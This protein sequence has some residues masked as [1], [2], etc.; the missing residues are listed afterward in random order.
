MKNLKNYL[1]KL[2][3][4]TD[5]SIKE[6]IVIITSFV[7]SS[8]LDLIGIGLLSIYVTLLINPD[9]IVNSYI[10]TKYHFLS[11]ITSFNQLANIVGIILVI[12][13]VLKLLISV[14]IYNIVFKFTHS[15]Q[16]LLRQKLLNSYKKLSY[17][18]Y[19]YRDS[20]DSIASIGVYVKNYGAVING[21]LLFIGDMIIAF[22]IVLLLLS[23][24][25]PFF[26]SIVFLLTLVVYLYKILLLNNFA[27]LGENL[28]KGYKSIY[29]GVQ[30]Y[31]DGFKE[32][33]VLNR[34]SYFEDKIIS[35]TDKVA[36]SDIKQSIIAAIPK[37][38]IELTIVI[39]MV[40]IVSYTIIT[41]GIISDIIPLLTLFAAASIRLAPMFNQISRFFSS[42]SYGQNSILKLYDENPD[43]IL[44]KSRRNEVISFVKGGL[45][46]LS[47]S[48][49]TFDWGIKVPNDQ[50]HIMYVWLDALS[51]YPNSLG[52][53]SNNKSKLS[54]YWSNTVHI[55]GKDILRHHAVYW[56]AFLLSAKLELPKRIFAHGWWT[57]E[58]N[59]ISKSLGNTIDPIE[60]I[61]QFGLDQIRYFLLREI[62][63]GSDGDFSTEALKSRINA[64]LSNDLGNLCQRSLTMIVKHCGAIIPGDKNITELD[65]K[66]LSRIS[67]ELS[68][69]SLHVD[70]QEINIYIKKIWDVVAS[71]NK[72]FNDN[73][74]W[75]LKSTDKKRFESVLF[76]TAETIKQIAVMI[77]PIMPDT[78]KRILDFYNIDVNNITLEILSFNL[79]NIKINEIN[80]LFPRVE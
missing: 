50:K 60:I 69:L 42:F 44:P 9:L 5:A 26:L 15:R 37:L 66:L 76:V 14:L 8:L 67:N 63:F 43:F 31:F 65:K 3:K 6:L 32:L 56:P 27:K 16:K 47:I 46:D 17:E 20:S 78:S 38:M 34:Y 18:K 54:S 71:A 41:G 29:Q 21:L 74:P 72:Y 4:L 64:D 2:N 22:F 35:G 52:Y 80:P 48:R 10:F 13:F 58:G 30:E 77:Y 79:I 1:Y 40:G 23:F 33:Y 73:K 39:L 28:N 59:K 45:R 12:L 68:D 51:S 24:N 11:E 75:E 25:G 57:N 36:N 61:D 7:A 55:I 53:I 70:N 62:T 19:I 49:N